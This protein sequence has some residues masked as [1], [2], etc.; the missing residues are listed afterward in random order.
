[1]ECS[2]LFWTLNGRE[3][4]STVQ[5]P[6]LDRTTTS[7][8]THSFIRNTLEQFDNTDGVV[9]AICYDNNIIGV[10]GYNY[11][12]WANHIGQLGYWLDQSHQGQG[13]MTRACQ[14]FV[15]YSFATLMLNRVV[16]LCAT[17]NSRSR[18]IPERLGFSHEGTT[19]ESEWLYD[20]FVDHEIYALLR[21]HW[22]A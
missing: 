8:D 10:I 14:F 21:R 9:A 1:M 22:V 7:A 15:N 11:I 13:I 5:L 12:D 20:H 2:F 4:L 17:H 16:I 18:A 19:R 6:W 3:K